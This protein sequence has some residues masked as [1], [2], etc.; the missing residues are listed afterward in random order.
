MHPLQQ[1]V[2]LILFAVHF[3]DEIYNVQGAEDRVAYFPP[4]NRVGSQVNFPIRGF[5]KIKNSWCFSLFLGRYVSTLVAP[6][7]RLGF[8]FSLFCYD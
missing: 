4:Q 7:V 5:S 6:C 2:D 3:Y 1:T 8:F